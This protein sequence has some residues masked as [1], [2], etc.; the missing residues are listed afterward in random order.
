M[1]EKRI[2]KL[3]NLAVLIITVACIGAV[4]E[5]YTQGWEYWV[6]PLIIAG[7]IAAWV[8]H[9]TEYKDAAFREI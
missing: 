6:P 3:H 9:L 5:S 1:N 4:V 7:I 2:R 8:M